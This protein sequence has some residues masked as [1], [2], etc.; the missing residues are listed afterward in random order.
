VDFLTSFASLVRT[1]EEA[2]SVPLARGVQLD[3]INIFDLV[4]S[5]VNKRAQALGAAEHLTPSVAADSEADLARQERTEWQ[6]QTRTLYWRSG[7]YS[8]VRVGDW[9]LQ[10]ALRPNKVWFF[11]LRA[12][13]TEHRNLALEVNVTTQES[14]Q[15]LLAAQVSVLG[16]NYEDGDANGDVGVSFS[17]EFIAQQLQRIHG[18]WVETNSQQVPPRWPA[19]SETPVTIDKVFQDKQVPGDEYVHWPN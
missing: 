9:K 12:D 11:N 6:S 19:A 1:T 15:D 10:I 2:R 16:D 7:H 13:P 17:A 4:H 18:K 3:G 14:L 5:A 8:A